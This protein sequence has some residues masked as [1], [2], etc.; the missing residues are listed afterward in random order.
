MLSINK[1]GDLAMMVRM[2]EIDSP[3]PPKKKP[4]SEGREQMKEVYEDQVG[5]SY[6][7]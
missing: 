2:P 7:L 5:Y 3:P 1:R 4:R 6:P